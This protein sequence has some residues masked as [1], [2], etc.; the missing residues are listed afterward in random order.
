[1]T[2]SGA[3][4]LQLP[5]HRDRVEVFPTVTKPEVVAAGII[6]GYEND[7]ALETDG[8]QSIHARFQ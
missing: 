6:A 1:M 8:A 3:E 4:L 2:I 7:R 5:R